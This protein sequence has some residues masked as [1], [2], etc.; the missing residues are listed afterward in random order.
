MDI[1]P[2]DKLKY[3]A[4]ER[5][6]NLIYIEKDYFLTAFLYL[7]KD[8]KGI[9]LKGG[10][11]LNK[12]FLGHNRL[13]EDLDFAADR[14]IEEIRRDI[15]L[16]IKGVRHFKRIETD[17]STQSFIRYRVYYKSHFQKESFIII[18]INKKATVHLAAESHKVPNFY[19][20]NFSVTTLS[21][22]E[23]LAEKI[24]ALITRNQPRDYYDAYF[25]FKKHDVDMGLVKIKVEEAGE[26]FDTERIFRNARKIYSNWNSDLDLLTN[27][28]LDYIE[29]MKALKKRFQ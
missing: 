13:S 25:I 6:F 21:L 5:G 14:G 20:M 10:T 23:I 26:S 15:E 16:A 27:R 1:I 8:I 24:R 11:A 22:K 7:I 29:C 17:K 12:I 9:Y 4:G 19:G 2:E 3:I 18:D 28:K